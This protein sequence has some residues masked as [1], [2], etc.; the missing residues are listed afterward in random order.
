VSAA[1]SELPAERL[2]GLFSELAELL[3]CLSPE[4]LFRVRKEASAVA[5]DA[6]GRALAASPGAGKE[7]AGPRFLTVREAG[8][9]L[10]RS[11]SWLYHNGRRL[12]LSVRDGGRLRFPEERLRRYEQSLLRRR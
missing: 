6:L 3:P 11:T 10:R 1:F 2:S 5:E 8:L 12:G 4:D 7:D 9:R